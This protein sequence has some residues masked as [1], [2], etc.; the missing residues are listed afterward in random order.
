MESE[1][2]NNDVHSACNNCI[3]LIVGFSFINCL[4]SITRRLRRWQI[5]IFTES[6]KF[7]DALQV[8]NDEFFKFISFFKPS[9]LWSK[10]TAISDKA[11]TKI[12]ANVTQN[13]FL[14]SISLFLKS[15]TR[16]YKISK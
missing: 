4:I 8:P 7:A 3:P 1:I 11:I 5:L 2:F 13:T 14:C 16:P 9:V 6:L 10:S 12:T 15:T